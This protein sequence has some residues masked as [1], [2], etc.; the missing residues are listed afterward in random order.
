[1][2]GSGGVCLQTK[3]DHLSYKLRETFRYIQV[4]EC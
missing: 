1:L 4:S 3:S 2:R